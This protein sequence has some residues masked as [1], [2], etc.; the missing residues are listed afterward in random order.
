MCKI[1][2]TYLLGNPLSIWGEW[3]TNFDARMPTL[4]E[5]IGT[6]ARRE[7]TVCGDVL[8]LKQNE[9]TTQSCRKLELVVIIPSFGITGRNVGSLGEI[10]VQVGGFSRYEP[11]LVCIKAGLCRRLAWRDGARLEFKVTHVMCR[12]LHLDVNNL[13]RLIA[14]LNFC[15]CWTPECILRKVIVPYACYDS[16]LHLGATNVGR[17]GFDF[18][19]WDLMQARATKFRLGGL[20]SCEIG[21]FLG[22]RVHGQ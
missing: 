11:Q 14:R 18:L 9:I 10:R 7:T 16:T 8:P 4:W 1:L 5:F 15:C 19:F 6:I 21:V 22:S 20:Q 12:Q 17:L 3:S 13:S 2:S